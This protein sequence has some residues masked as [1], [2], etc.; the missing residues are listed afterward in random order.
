MPFGACV[1]GGLL[2]ECIMFFNVNC[3]S[4]FAVY[5]NALNSCHL[6]V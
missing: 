2:N 3:D 6:S 1:G 4:E 5:C